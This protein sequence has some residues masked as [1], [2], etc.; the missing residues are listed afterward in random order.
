MLPTC[1]T[2][3]KAVRFSWILTASCRIAI[4]SARSRQPYRGSVGGHDACAATAGAG[5][6]AVRVARGRDAG[7][8]RVLPHP[9][10]GHPLARRPPQVHDAR[11]GGGW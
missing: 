6:G 3:G 2:L 9:L 7:A 5:G 11:A 8:S 1:L 10:L 4:A